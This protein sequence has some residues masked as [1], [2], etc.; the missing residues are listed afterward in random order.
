MNRRRKLLIGF[1]LGVAV[2]AAFI[3][4]LWLSES[5]CP[6]FALKEALSSGTIIEPPVPPGCRPVSMEL[7]RQ[8]QDAISAWA[9]WYDLRVQRT[10][11][12]E[13]NLP[14]EEVRQFYSS[15]WKKRGFREFYQEG[16]G[17]MEI[18]GRHYAIASG[19]LSPDLHSTRVVAITAIQTRYT[20]FRLAFNACR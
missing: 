17:T 19:S 12:C 6:R 9:K 18:L 15:E 5:D 3:C 13:V 14:V 16:R 4:F 1:G 8:H 7:P 20:R 10:V 11:T 2:L